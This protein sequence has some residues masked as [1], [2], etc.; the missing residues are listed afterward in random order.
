[1]LSKNVSVR[2]KGTKIN[3]IDTPGHS[4]FGGEVERVLNMADGVIL[5]VDAFEGPMPQTRFVLGKAIELGL[6][7]VVVINK[8]DKPNCTPEE[9]YE[10]VFELMFA[11]DASEDQLDF[12]VVYGSSKQ[13]WMGPDWKTP[14]E[15]VS[16]LLDVIVQHVPAPRQVEGTLQ[17]R[18]TSLDYSS[19]QGRIA[20]GRVSRGTVKAGQQVTLVKND[21]AQQKGQVKEL[22]VFEGLGKEKVKHEVGC[23]EIVAVMGLEGFDIGDTIADAENPEGL[24]RFSVDEPTMSMLFTIN[25]SPFFG[26]E[27]QFVTSRHVRDRLFKEIE[28]NLA[29]RIQETDSPDRLLVFGRGILHLSILVE[30]MRREG[31]EFQLG[32][33][34]VLYKDVDGQRHEPIEMLTVQVPEPFSSRV[35]DNVTRRKGEILNIEQKSDRTVLEFSIPARG[36]IGLRNVLLTATEGEAII[37]HRFKGYEPYK[38]QIAT[39]RPGC[40]VSAETGTAIAY[41]IDKLQDRGK[42]F[43]EPGEEVYA[44]Q[45]IGES[46]KPGEE[47]GVNVI[48]VKKL[49]NMRAS[50]SDDKVN[51]A[52][53]IKFSLE[54]C[55]EYIAEDEY[56]EVTPKS[57]RIRKI[58]LDENERKR[59]AKKL[60]EA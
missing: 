47:L 31:Y 41:A 23:G 27:G 26:R 10:A 38:G 12:P 6:K 22:M 18:I 1:I 50:G 48:R 14:T 36:I 2:Y 44:G 55:M 19:F 9:V 7:P 37:A 29:M 35:I 34:Q 59:A 39:P 21:G 54:E 46:P 16:H 51:I 30:T 33:P 3:I 60:Q 13:G 20:V 24:P 42:F 15:D 8:V 4:D 52:P 53:A 28:K 17:M 57:L 58:L 43:I 25:N 45:V 11:L 40:I 56:L 49:T 32:Q 5:L